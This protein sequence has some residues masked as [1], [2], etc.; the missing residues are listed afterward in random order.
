MATNTDN[1]NS[2]ASAVLIAASEL[3][4]AVTSW[5][6]SHGNLSHGLDLQAGCEPIRA[7][8]IAESTSRETHDLARLKTS[9][10]GMRKALDELGIA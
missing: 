3:R 6:V 9:I 5:E 7:G 1:T 2:A 8:S 4:D 10:V